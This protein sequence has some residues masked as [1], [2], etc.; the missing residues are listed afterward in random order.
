MRGGEGEGAE[1]EEEEEEEMVLGTI[2]DAN[3]NINTKALKGP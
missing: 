3:I 1:G 2:Q